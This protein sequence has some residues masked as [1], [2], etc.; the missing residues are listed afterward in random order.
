MTRKS[1]QQVPIV[2]EAL[3][4]AYMTSPGPGGQNVNK[5]ATAVRLRYDLAL[6]GLPEP[7]R[8]RAERLAG[9]RLSRAGEIVILANRFRSQ[10]DNRR[11]AL[12]RLMAILEA[13]WP[14]PA[15]RRE[16]RPGRGAVERRLSTKAR[17]GAVKAARGP[18]SD[19]G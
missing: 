19:D 10:A 9:R 12:L 4:F 6:A 16:S 7:V 17:R 18:V 13:A 15:E 3:S 5:V 8:L 2:A 1:H 11:D 14:A